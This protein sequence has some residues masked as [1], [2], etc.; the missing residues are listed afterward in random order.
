[1]DVSDVQAELGTIGLSIPTLN[2]DDS[3]FGQ[4]GK[5]GL[6]RIC[7]SESY[8]QCVKAR[9]RTSF[10]ITRRQEFESNRLFFFN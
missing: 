1:M 9:K 7:H 5:Q 10:G 2:L 3:K 4:N 6:H 8:S